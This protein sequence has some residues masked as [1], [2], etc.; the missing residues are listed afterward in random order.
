MV[1]HGP[2]EYVEVKDLVE[3]AETYALTALK[4]FQRA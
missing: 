1:S 4:L 2:K 3:C